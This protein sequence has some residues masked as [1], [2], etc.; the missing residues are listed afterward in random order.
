VRKLFINIIISIRNV[1][2]LSFGVPSWTLQEEKNGAATIFALSG[3]FY[4]D[5]TLDFVKNVLGLF[6]VYFTH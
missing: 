5:S 3:S 4:V 2:S 1:F 6:S